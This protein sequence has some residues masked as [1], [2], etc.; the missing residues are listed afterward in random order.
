MYHSV[1]SAPTASPFARYVVDPAVFGAQLQVLA[2]E[3]YRVASLGEVLSPE[4]MGERCVALTF[5]DAFGDFAE[6]ALP[7]MADF[8]MP[9]TLYVPT[10]FVGGT[11]RW[12]VP[13]G[14][15]GRRILGWSELAEVLA[16]GLVNI[17]AHSQTHAE[18]DRLGVADQRQEIM[19][20]KKM[21]EDHL[22]TPVTSF[23][24]PFGYHSGATERLVAEAGFTTGVTVGELPLGGKVRRRSVPRLTVSGRVDL[25]GFRALLGREAKLVR[26]ASNRVTP[27]A[28]RAYRRSPLWKRA[29]GGG[30]SCPGA[31]DSATP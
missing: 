3:G 30:S 12:L 17:G 22:Q 20:S 14:E 7:L 19:V 18:L 4:A 2:D 23:A 13:E 5:D 11:A 24:Y 9:S 1:S 28:W 6:Q 29:P 31:V 16:S 8:G 10:G 25:A 26:R 15:G 27:Y 21:L